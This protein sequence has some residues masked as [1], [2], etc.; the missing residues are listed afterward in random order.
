MAEDDMIWDLSQLVDSTDPTSI[1][2]RLK[3]MVSGAEEIRDRYHGEIGG[4]DT[5]DLLELLELKDDFTLQF[6]GV[7][8]YCRLAYS[9]DSTDEVAKQLND[10]ARRSS[11]RVDQKLAFIDLELGNLLAE[12]PSLVE[13][14]LLA[15]YRHYLER[16]VRKVPHMLSEQQERLIILKDKNGIEGWQ[17]LQ[18]DW[19]STRTFDIEIDGEMRTLP[20]GEIIGFYESPDRDLRKRANQIVYQ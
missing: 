14:P 16:M 19:L 6:E 15:E 9:A 7:T 8:M 2:Q 13:D 18:S 4:L 3:S 1:K 5:G 17:M 20:Y 11:T 12:N 10:A